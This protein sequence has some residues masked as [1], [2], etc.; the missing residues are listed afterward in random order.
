MSRGRRDLGK[1]DHV[2]GALQL[3]CPSGHILGMALVQNGRYHL[4]GNPEELEHEGGV[5]YRW[6]CER[7]LKTNRKPDLQASWAKLRARL[8]ELDKDRTVGVVKYTIG[9][10]QID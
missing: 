3:Q 1:T 5:K 8:E 7:C 2:Y 9:G 6:T 10:N 4:E